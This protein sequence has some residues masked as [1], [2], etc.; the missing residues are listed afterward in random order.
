MNSSR[1]ESFWQLIGQTGRAMRSYA[2]R[3]L[4]GYSLTV[5]QLQ[6]LKNIDAVVGLPQSELCQLTGKSPANITRILDRL[7]KKSRIERRANPTDRRSSLIFLTGE[8]VALCDEVNRLFTGLRADLVVGISSDK[9][10]IA[11]EVLREIRCNI[12]KMDVK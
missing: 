3:C 10:R 4:R 8:G 9:Q 1:E 7:E 11:A 5:E 2:D 12:E 6:V